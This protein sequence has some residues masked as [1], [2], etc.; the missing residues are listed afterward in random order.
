MRVFLKLSAATS[1]CLLLTV[2]LIV[3]PGSASISPSV[4]LGSV[5]RWPA[6]ARLAGAVPS[7]TALHL[8]VTLRPRDAT[9]L[10]AYAAAVSTPGSSVFHRYLSVAQFARRFGASA[11]Q[12]AA[13]KRS[14]RAHG[15]RPGRV[16][17]NGLAISVAGSA[18]AVTHAFS[19]S[20]DR[21]KL[22]G[23][24][25]AFAN[26]QAP[27]LD[28]S[29]V[30]AVQGV[31]GLEDA[32]APQ[33]LALQ[34]LSRRAGVSV[35][36]RVVTGGTQP[37]AGARSAAASR[38]TTYT[39]DQV[40]STYGF[41]GLYAAGDKG[42]G[43]TIALYE[44]EASL[45]SDVAAYQRCYGTSAAVSYRTVDGGPAPLDVSNE[46]GLETALDIDGV[47]GLAPRAKV[48][49]Y[50]GPNDGSG[51]Y[52]TYSAIITQNQARVISTSW[53][54]CEADIGSQAQAEATLFQEAAVQ[55]QTVLA[56][57][58]DT[59]AEG[60]NGDTPYATSGQLAVGDPASQPDV[61]SVG[62]TSLRLAPPRTETVWRN[63][64][65]AS[66]GGVSSVWPMPSYQAGAPAALNVIGPDSSSAPCQTVSGYCRQ[67]PDVSA[68]G[69]P[70]TGLL[71][72]Y[73]GGWSTVGGTS[74]DAPLWAALI[75]LVNA[76]PACA[77]VP[78]GFANPALYRAAARA[79][80]AD[81]HDV[82]RG[83]NDLTQ[84]NGGLYP[85]AA[86][87][88][89]A[90]GLGTPVASALA[91]TLCPPKLT[92]TNPGT[93]ANMVGSAPRLYVHATTNS[94]AAVRYSASGLPRGLAINPSTG[95]ISGKPSAA[96]NYSV[97]LS[98]AVPGASAS[99]RFSWA[100]TGLPGVTHA[101]LTGI[102]TGR[103]R[104]AFT[105]GAGANATTRAVAITLPP[106]LTFTAGATALPQADVLAGA[107]GAGVGFSP[108]L[109]QGRL[110]LTL[111]AGA[112]SVS[113]AIAGSIRPSTSLTRSVKARQVSVLAVAVT[114][115]NTR[116]LSAKLTLKLRPS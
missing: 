49:V 66:G 10:A 96:G 109:S 99:A 28:R 51:S 80:T 70:G 40:A 67:V 71:A 39:A 34:R 14:L 83:N 13:V 6:G 4:R 97:T 57:A 18:G 92:V 56:A 63:S 19:V 22:P 37:C 54:A 114:A 74:A 48:L 55:G 21:L 43:Q 20:L 82:L 107:S 115:T 1:A 116:G 61:T 90:S 35:A 106:G 17:A 103:P 11:R 44:L 84:T 73:A 85:A 23:G 47:I 65:G 75:A 72:Y 89:M 98:A 101:S 15:L 60:C 42:A 77:G 2:F 36:P 91:R 12:I 25:T 53:G 79:Y 5:A 76:Q 7:S 33:P 41:S 59:G 112:R 108:S 38:P 26:R 8:A 16:S 105:L 45:P 24:R 88:D 68:D 27:L 87:Y 29:V 102:A 62:G 93:R 94:G 31:V 81:F 58:G 86:G 78:L 50:Q 3:P 64:Y 100:I 69:D 113:L 104:L 46:D 30:S 32:S 52:D 111:A 110:T 9:G 95:L